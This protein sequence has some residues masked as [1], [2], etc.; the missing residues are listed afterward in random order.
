MSLFN[1]E[2]LQATHQE[3]LQ[4]A[5]NL[6]TNLI[7]NANKLGKLQQ[8]AFSQLVSKQ[9][10]LANKFFAVRDTQQLF[11]LQNEFFSPS[12]VLEQQLNFNREVV[13]V[14]SDS[15]QQVSQF[16]EQQ[17]AKNNQQF[18]EAVEHFAGQAPA[19]S[20]QAVTAFK[21]AV[22]NAN[23]VFGQAQAAAKNA[24]TIAEQA[25]KQAAEQTE[26]TAREVAQTTEKNIATAK[27]ATEQQAKGA[28]STTK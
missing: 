22:S 9:F 3:S 16:A 1:T 21:S 24:S 5:Q 12:A 19:G 11:D 20:E 2:K 28:R 13:A 27:A 8:D 18:N 25:V 14:L 15:Q 10:E 17:L 26:K 23:Q 6:T 4:V 7:T